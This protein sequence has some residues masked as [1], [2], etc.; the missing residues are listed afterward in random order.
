MQQEG[1]AY[2]KLG[3]FK[4]E[5]LNTDGNYVAG[6][7]DIISDAERRWMMRTARSNLKAPYTVNNIQQDFSLEEQQG[8]LSE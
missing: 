3:P 1:D 7:H 5:H 4:L 8:A 6:V 2:L